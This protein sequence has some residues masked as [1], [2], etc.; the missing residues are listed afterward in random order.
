MPWQ[1]VVLLIIIGGLVLGVWIAF[2]N[3]DRL[4]GKQLK[5]L[6]DRTTRPI[7]PDAAAKDAPKPEEPAKDAPPQEPKSPGP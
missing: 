1:D 4:A 7:P 2:L 6:D 5:E 3:L